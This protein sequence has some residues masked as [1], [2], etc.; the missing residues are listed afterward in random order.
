[1]KN[2][3]MKIIKFFLFSIF[4]QSVNNFCQL[5]PTFLFM[6]CSSEA[7]TS[8]RGNTQQPGY[9]L[10]IAMFLKLHETL[11]FLARIIWNQES[12][13]LSEKQMCENLLE[14]TQNRIWKLSLQTYVF[15]LQYR[16]PIPIPKIR[17]TRSSLLEQKMYYA[18]E[19]SRQCDNTYIA[20]LYCHIV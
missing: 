18:V 2:C 10:P 4:Y 19:V 20:Y 16:I 17:Q 12:F 13:C 5:F 1:M 15:Q 14:E 6:L 9:I 3:G 7:I 8:H 11:N